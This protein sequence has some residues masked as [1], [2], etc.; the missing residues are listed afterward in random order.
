M[1]LPEITV[2]RI[3]L[4]KDCIQF[5]GAGVKG[6]CDIRKE[7]AEGTDRACKVMQA[8]PQSK[9]NQAKGTSA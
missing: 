1:N 8:R 6:Y 5:N 4:C 2:K 3:M 7:L 9:K